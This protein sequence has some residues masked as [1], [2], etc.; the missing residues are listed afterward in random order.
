MAVKVESKDLYVYAIFFF[1]EDGDG[2]R[3]EL[4]CAP[5]VPTLKRTP[6]EIQNVRFP[7]SQTLEWDSDADFSGTDTEYELL[8][9]DVTDWPVGITCTE[10]VT[11][12]FSATTTSVSDPLPN[13]G[14][15]YLVR[16]V[17]GCLE[18]VG[19][20]GFRSEECQVDCERIAP[21]P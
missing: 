17:N 14:S 10:T 9:G 1:D 6:G 2:V 18:G 13:M 4:D 11:G 7:D 5:T 16:G 21:C 3:D 8:T 20:W 15:Y 12:P 19:T